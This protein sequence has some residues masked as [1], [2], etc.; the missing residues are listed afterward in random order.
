MNP[1][2]KRKTDY[3][4]PFAYLVGD[5]LAV[6]SAFV[7]AFILRVTYSSRPSSYLIKFNSYFLII[8]SLIP[9]FIA[10]FYL[11]GLYK[12]EIIRRR[13]K[14][15][16]LLI[17]ASLGGV[18]ALISVDYFLPN[19]TLFPAKLVP[20]YAAVLAIILL[21]IV[22]SILRLS[23]KTLW[24]FNIGAERVAIIGSNQATRNLSLALSDTKTSGYK[25]VA[26][27]TSKRYKPEIELE[28]YYSTPQS[29]L[30]DLQNLR[31]DSIIKTE[32]FDSAKTNDDIRRA[33]DRNHIKF[34]Y[35]P[36]DDNLT[37]ANSEIELLNNYPILTVNQTP[38]Q[39]W[40]R[41]IKRLMDTSLS[42]I[43]I[44]I[45]G[46]L[47]LIIALL[48]KIFDSGPVFFKNTRVTRYGNTFKALK[49]RTMKQEFCVDDQKKV[50]K[51]LIDMGYP[52][53]AE[54][55]GRGEKLEFDP[56]I[57]KIGN[58]L[59]KTSLDE[60]PQLFNIL[61][62]QMSFVGPRAIVKDELKFYGG[63]DYIMLSVKTGL[64]GLAQ[65][66]GR[67]DINYYER[68]RLDIYYVQHWNLWM[69]ISILLRTIKKIFSGS[70][71]K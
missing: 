20:I 48:I 38:L 58:F 9:I 61:M 69:D 26:L 65:V 19:E 21:L 42:L 36:T 51:L 39:G 31:L 49:F 55:F 13:F 50:K 6:I 67:S 68:A 59:R 35:L 29:L 46:P 5:M 60:L 17:I 63:R 64:T 62:G 52:V 33:A 3:I 10:I 28:N 7:L 11:S 1:L 8:L 41:I 16:L 24:R 34:K 2:N 18:M 44:I 22:R 47:M 54:Q 56:R 37:G 66:T 27:A 57:S 32:S 14:E 43:S 53:Q 23:F 40:G 30:K 70:G 4:I 15:T 71:S 25:I 12:K 45:F